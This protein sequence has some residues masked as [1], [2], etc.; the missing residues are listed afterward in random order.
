M[1]EE[2]GSPLGKFIL[3]MTLIAGLSF[4]FFALN[5]T[6]GG[7]ISTLGY[8]ADEITVALIAFFSASTIIG[9]YLVVLYR[10]SKKEVRN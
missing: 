4:V 10:K 2:L 7:I 6:L 3:L 1:S 8:V 9:T 5:F